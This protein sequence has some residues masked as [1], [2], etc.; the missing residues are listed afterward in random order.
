[1]RRVLPLTLLMK[2]VL[3][4]PVAPITA[5]ATSEGSTMR[6]VPVPPE[7]DLQ[8]E[9]PWSIPGG[10][11]RARITVE[12]GREGVVVS[13]YLI[14]MKE[15]VASVRTLHALTLLLVRLNAEFR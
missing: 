10:R 11:S 2:V 6:V 1:M 3:P 15:D 13:R 8:E 9:M 7:D 4:L 12:A 14:R 5:M